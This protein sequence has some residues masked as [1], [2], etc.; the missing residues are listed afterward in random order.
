MQDPEQRNQLAAPLAIWGMKRPT[1]MWIRKKRENGRLVEIILE[2]E[3]LLATF[4]LDMSCVFGGCGW[5]VETFGLKDVI[6]V[7]FVKR[8]SVI[9][10]PTRKRNSLISI[11]AC[12]HRA[13]TDH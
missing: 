6:R 5:E 1:E 11:K 7:G 12:M 8:A 13:S 10:E 4:V 3:L 9:K 2:K